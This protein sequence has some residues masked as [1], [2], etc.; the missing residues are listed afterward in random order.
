MLS[1]RRVLESTLLLLLAL[2][3]GWDTEGQVAAPAERE[4]DVDDDGD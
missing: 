4:E 2:G 3:A 1:E